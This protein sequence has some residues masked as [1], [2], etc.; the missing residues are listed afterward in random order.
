MSNYYSGVIQ[1]RLR[2]ITKA[3]RQ[4]TTAAIDKTARDA[5]QKLDAVV[6]TWVNKPAFE[7]TSRDTG[8]KIIREVSI[9]GNLKSVRIWGYVDRGTKPHII[10]AKKPGGF[11]RFGSKY[12]P[13]TSYRA[14][15]GGSGKSSGKPVFRQQVKH[16]GNKGREFGEQYKEEAAKQL[17]VEIHREL[18]RRL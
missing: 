16:P 1:K 18:D 11:L 10:R 2:D 5:Q 8:Y 12:Q 7:I 6:A 4:A 9:F 13:K 17:R 14:K 15:F 3:A